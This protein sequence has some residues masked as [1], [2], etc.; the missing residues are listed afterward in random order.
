M[1][2]DVQYM[3]EKHS[4]TNSQ[5]PDGSIEAWSTSEG[6]HNVHRDRR[7]R[8]SREEERGSGREKEETRLSG[9]QQ[10]GGGGG[11]R[12][13]NQ[14]TAPCSSLFIMSAGAD[15]RVGLNAD[16]G[17]A[18]PARPPPASRLLGGVALVTRRTMGAFH[19]RHINIHYPSQPPLHCNYFGPER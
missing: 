9:T 4:W 13:A 19:L 6:T 16:G 2:L 14:W 3:M 17:A 18:L 12:A 11:P 15:R 5:K 7:H 8:A 10:I 1:V